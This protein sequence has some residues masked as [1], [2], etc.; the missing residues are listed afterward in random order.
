M[1]C[2]ALK[3]FEKYMFLDPRPS[4]PIPTT[5]RAPAV[6]NRPP[7]IAI[8]GYY[9][10]YPLATKAQYLPK[11][12]QFVTAEDFTL[13]RWFAYLYKSCKWVATSKS[14]HFKICWI[15]NQMINNII[16]KEIEAAF[17]WSLKNGNFLL[18]Q[19]RCFCPRWAALHDTEL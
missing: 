5:V 8:A 12:P 6:I 4:S 3:T 17:A 7:Q 15:L 10:T 2:V 11:R 14:M 19:R 18:C 16:K 13:V 1:F 9:P